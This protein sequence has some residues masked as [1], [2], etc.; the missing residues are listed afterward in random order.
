MYIQLDLID[1]KLLS[2]IRLGTS[3]K[4]DLHI[5]LDIFDLVRRVIV[6]IILDQFFKLEEFLTSN[7]LI[8]LSPNEKLKVFDF[9]KRPH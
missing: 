1:Y 5:I 7:Q 6:C 4:S 3:N 8:I 9:E 2:R